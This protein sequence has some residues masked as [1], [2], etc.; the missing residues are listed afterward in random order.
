MTNTQDL[1]MFLKLLGYN[2]LE[3]FNKDKRFNQFL[4]L[5]RLV[6]ILNS[7]SIEEFFNNN[8]GA[9]NAVFDFVFE[10]LD[11]FVMKRGRVIS[12]NDAFQKLNKNGIF[13]LEDVSCN[14]SLHTAVLNKSQ[15]TEIDYIGYCFTS[16]LDH[17]RRSFGKSFYL[18]FGTTSG[19]S[20]LVKLDKLSL[21]IGE[22]IIKVLN[23]C[24]VRSKWYHETNYD[25]EV[26]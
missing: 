25:I 15:E 14:T 20:D 24:G 18:K 7:N 26:I 9:V 10:N 13:C 11:H 12:L 22:K 19:I 5:S 23:E 8:P 16:S 4:A 3:E 17:A 2:S 21:K 1:V 6:T